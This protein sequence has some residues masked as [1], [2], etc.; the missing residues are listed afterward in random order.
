MMETEKLA[1]EHKRKEL[2]AHGFSLISVTLAV[3]MIIV[4][5][6]YWEQEDC[7][8]GASSYLY[9]G[10]VFSLTINVLGLATSVAKWLALKVT[11]MP[12]VE[13]DLNV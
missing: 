8:L 10:G 4:G 5:S 7:K 11:Q 6:I 12:F 1:E 3:A 2:S 9:Y 13:I